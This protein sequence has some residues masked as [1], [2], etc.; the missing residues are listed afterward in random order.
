VNDDRIHRLL[1]DA[2]PS[3]PSP[4]GWADKVARRSARRRVGVGAL[5]V[6]IAVAL[7]VTLLLNQ[8]RPRVAEPEPSPSAPTSPVPVDSPT[9]PVVKEEPP[10]KGEIVGI[11]D[12]Y[13]EPYEE[14]P[15]I[16]FGLITASLPGH[17]SGPTLLGEFDWDD[18]PHSEYPTGSEARGQLSADGT[19]EVVG[20]LDYSQGDN[21]TFTLTRPVRQKD[22]VYPEDPPLDLPTLCDDPLRDADPATADHEAEQ[23]LEEAVRRLPT[24]SVW[25][26]TGGEGRNILVR[27][28]AEEA[29]TELRKAWGGWLC[30]D[31]SE[32]PTEKERKKALDRVMDVRP[33]GSFTIASPGN[34]LDFALQLD[35]V[36]ADADLVAAIHEAAGE[37]IDVRITQ[38]FEPYTG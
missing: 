25:I 1:E 35:L 9:A 21:G 36:Y 5:A 10:R 22:R 13:Q 16:C 26:G 29:F 37:G 23:A 6:A 15:H 12:I 30:V 3:A 27:G 17:C 19:Y 14:L 20:L 4:T 11:V 33:K 28:D 8:E 2:V 7:P 18:V 34:I 24:V 38:V 32:L 31:S